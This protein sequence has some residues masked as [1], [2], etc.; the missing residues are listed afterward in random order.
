MQQPGKT[1]DVQMIIEDL[2][3]C[4]ITD[5]KTNTEIISLL[6]GFKL[7]HNSEITQEYVIN[8]YSEDYNMFINILAEMFK[9]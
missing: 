7:L 4:V 8:F 2:G 9:L 6:Y 3:D 1:I 5:I